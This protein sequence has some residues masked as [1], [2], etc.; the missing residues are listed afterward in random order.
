MLDYIDTIKRKRISN[1]KAQ[2][3][4]I[5]KKLGNIEAQ[6]G[7]IKKKLSNIKA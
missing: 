1:A 5:I 2:L 3:D 6:L 7:T 4:T